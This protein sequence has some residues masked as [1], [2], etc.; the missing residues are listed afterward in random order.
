MG[1]PCWA[2]LWVPSCALSAVPSRWVAV[3]C[4][5]WALVAGAALAQACGLLSLT[6]PSKVL[7]VL[8]LSPAGL[9]PPK[10]GQPAFCRAYGVVACPGT[11][12]GREVCAAE[13]HRRGLDL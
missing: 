11:L 9:I 8:N 2:V 13:F 4:S 12:C 6:G 3:A 1:L 5:A 7:C 10:S